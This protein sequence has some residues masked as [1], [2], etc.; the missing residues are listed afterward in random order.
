MELNNIDV[1]FIAL[2]YGFLVFG[3]ASAVALILFG[4]RGAAR[5]LVSMIL[6]T[7]LLPWFLRPSIF[8]KILMAGFI[9]I[10]GL[11]ALQWLAA[12]VI[13]KHAA[14]SM[15]GSLAADLV[16]GVFKIAFRVLLGFARGSVEVI[17]FLSKKLLS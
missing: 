6:Y 4:S 15:V 14:D 8:S 10:T 2:G 12:L 7:F 13:G 9:A 16:R 3:W 5:V 11:V 1:I 17:H